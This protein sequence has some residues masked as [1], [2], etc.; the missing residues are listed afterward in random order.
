MVEFVHKRPIVCIDVIELSK[1]SNSEC[2]FLVLLAKIS[3]TI[4]MH[5]VNCLTHKLQC[6]FLHMWHL[7]MCNR[8]P[9]LV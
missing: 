4:Y 6:I 3:P 7:H 1:Y 2:Y 8:P 5:G 9:N